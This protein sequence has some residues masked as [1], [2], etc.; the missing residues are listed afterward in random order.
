MKT[1]RFLAFL[2]VLLIFTALFYGCLPASGGGKANGII[3]AG[4]GI[5]TAHFID[6]GQ[7]DSIFIELPDRKCILIDAGDPKAGRTVSDYIGALGYKEIDYL[8]ATHPHADHI[9]GMPLVVADYEI[10]QVWIPECDTTTQIYEKL[11]LA[12]IDK[13]AEIN[14]AKAGEAMISGED[15]SAVFVSPCRTYEDMNDNSAV[16]KLT[17]K[18]RSFLFAGDAQGES[19]GEITADITADIVKAG[20]HGSDTSSGEDFIK[21]TGA[22]AVIISVGGDN[23]YGHPSAS[24]ISRWQSSGAAVYRTDE[25]KTI[26]VM[27]DG[28]KTALLYG[29]NIIEIKPN[30]EALAA[31]SAS[32]GETVAFP[33]ESSSSAT[34]ADAT[35]NDTSKV[36]TSAATTA[37]TTAATA[38]TTTAATTAAATTAAATTAATTAAATSSEVTS[39][40]TT[41]GTT[42]AETTKS[43]DSTTAFFRWVLNTSSKK[44]HCP[45]CSYVSRIAEKNYAVS[46][47]SIAQL[48]AEGYT[49]CKVCNPEN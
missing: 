13:G 45:G 42:S 20:H 30:T 41:E 19:E 1:K 5:L 34:E 38:A 10:G 35:V 23:E 9:G 49:I 29:K 37:T 24:V 15:I 17:Y 14:T 2:G 26:E 12:L 22:A 27:T 47:K 28:T 36:T 48:E 18:E 46:N 6:V 7:G 32:A 40:V 31:A 39:A 3:N 8:V 4:D 21:R 16:L 43:A 44:I 11:L 33:K 25:C